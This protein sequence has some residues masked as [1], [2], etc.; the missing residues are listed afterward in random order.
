MLSGFDPRADADAPF[1]YPGLFNTMGEVDDARDLS[2]RRGIISPYRCLQQT[3]ASE[4]L[5]SSISNA[6]QAADQKKPKPSSKL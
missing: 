3:S 4:I 5:P 2:L 6:K 1:V